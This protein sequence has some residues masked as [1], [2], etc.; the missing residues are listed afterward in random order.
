MGSKQV[1]F[2]LNPTLGYNFLP[3]NNSEYEHD[4]MSR[5]SK[6]FV[7]KTAPEFTVKNR[8]NLISWNEFYLEAN[9]MGFGQI[10]HD[11]VKS[12][13][14]KVD[15]NQTG[16]LNKNEIRLALAYLHRLYS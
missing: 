7:Q 5:S 16:Y 8:D 1:K 6:S 3:N 14:N 4:M 9:E 2:Q 15:R 11:V 13:F 10:E 12:A